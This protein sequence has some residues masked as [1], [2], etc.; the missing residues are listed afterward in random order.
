M[1]RVTFAPAPADVAGES[2]AAAE[3]P[4][5][6]VVVR[7]GDGRFAVALGEVAEVGKPPQV[8][9]VPD[10]PG[11]VAG[12]VNWRGRILAVLDLGTLLGADAAASG[13]AARLV[14]LVTDVATV[15]VLVDGVEGTAALG[16]EH[17]PVPAAICGVGADLV[18]G[19]VPR[20]DGPV[21]VLDVSAVV[22][23]RELLPRSRHNK[24]GSWTSPSG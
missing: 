1:M 14:V 6:A 17:E 19:Q 5:D 12:V 4:E 20:D 24:E 16:D 11:W 3:R 10:A 7:L 22:R 2:I 15:G 13:P 21:A 9:R 18:R 8:T 23:L